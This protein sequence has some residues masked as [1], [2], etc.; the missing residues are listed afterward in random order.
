MMRLTS[1]TCGSVSLSASPGGRSRTCRGRVCFGGF[2]S[3][4]KGGGQGGN[5]PPWAKCPWR[6]GRSGARGGLASCSQ[7]RYLGRWTEQ[8][9]GPGVREALGRAQWADAQGLEEP[10]AAAA[11]RSKAPAAGS[12]FCSGL[13]FCSRSSLACLHP[14]G[15]N[16]L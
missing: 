7:I 9:S 8:K 10:A 15:Q 2:I 11:P 16:V 5:A 6:T 1:V 12:G 4:S 13:G 3:F 14:M